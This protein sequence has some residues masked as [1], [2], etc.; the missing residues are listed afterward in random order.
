VSLRKRPLEEEFLPY[1]KTLSL[2]ALFDGE[3]NIDWLQ[4]LTGGKASLIFAALE[5]GV[6]NGWLSSQDSVN[7][8]FIES[9]EQQKLQDSLS[10]D[11]KETMHRSIA[12]L[13]LQNVPDGVDTKKRVAHHFLYL[14]NDLDGCRLLIERGD[15]HRRNFRDD[16]ARLYY[17]K[18]INDLRCHKG[19]QG[20]RLF[21]EAALQYAKVS[22]DNTDPTRVI[23]IVK[24][25]IRRAKSCG[26]EDS[27]GFLEMHLGKSEWLRSRYRPALRHFK[28]GWAL[29]R[30][31][32]DPITQRSATIFGIFFHYWSGNYREA[33]QSYE[34]FVPDVEDTFPKGSL[35]LLAA[36]TAG[37]CLGHTGLYSQALGML[38]AIREHSQ[39]IGNLSIAGLAGTTIGHLL[40]ELNRPEDSIQ[41]IEASLD[42]TIK[43]R[44]I[45]SHLGGLGLLCYAFHLVGDNTRA[46]SILREYLDLSSQA[47]M[48][49]KFSAVWMWICWAMEEGSFPRV[50]GL[51]LEEEIDYSIRSGNLLMKGVAYRYKALLQRKKDQPSDDIIRV[52]KRSVTH[53]RVCGHQ[54]ELAKSEVELAREYLRLGNEKKAMEWAEPAVKTLYSLND[55][56]VPDDIRPLVKDLRS[57]NLLEEILRLSQE[58]T[59]IRDHKDLSRRIISTINRITG[60]ERGAIF[61]LEDQTPGKI[62]LRAAKNLTSEDITMPDFQTP[63]RLIEETAKTG[64]GRI[65]ELDIREQ[66]TSAG[67]NAIRSCICVPMTIRN[68]AMGVLYHD[69]RLFRS[70]FKESDLKILDYFA[71]QA[72]IAIDNAQAWKT[73]NELY[74]KQ[75]LEKQYYEKEYLETIH[76][77]DFV[78]QSPAVKKVF[79]QVEQVAETDATVLILG[80]TGV[81]KEL[82]A[83]S[84]H[85]NSPRSKKP[86]IRVQCSAL[87]E[88]LISSELFGHERGAFTGATAQHIGRFELAN[89]GTIF[90]DEIGDISMDVQVRLLRVLQSREFERVGGHETLRSDFRLLAA[91]NR[92]LQ[93][94]VRTGH[95]RQDLYYR[96]NVFPIDVPRLRDREGDIQL[97]AYYFLKLYAS[98]FNKPLESIPKEEMGKLLA[99]DWP[100]NVREL[101]NV[102]ERGVILSNGPYYNVPELEGTHSAVSSEPTPI[103]LRDNERDHIIRVLKKTGGKV[104]G[105]GGA[106]DLL[107]IHPNTLFSRMK[108]LGIQRQAH[109]ASKPDLNLQSP[110]ECNTI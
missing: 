25:A 7:F 5:F 6:T 62:V 54:V 53:L 50:E 73:L 93:R 12:D 18:A 36:L 90:L 108:K 37:A 76:F 26:N 71:A 41:C 103:R 79:S 58:L 80:E 35:P 72:A 88:T 86:F 101:E 14:S 51:S 30:E 31:I 94:E 48:T 106:A 44:S 63:M 102:I 52:L 2:A 104:T 22:A 98:K 43:S 32:D 23:S 82:V 60:A 45:Y 100:G 84:I 89:G 10:P 28:K 70:A 4:E 65:L 49:V 56:L 20:D 27:V 38:H 74:E 13:L 109:Y 19:D 78:G 9:L 97:L 66:S 67:T 75:Q 87:P 16:E 110:S 61:L 3:F 8:S 91:T 57:G 17:D 99:Y 85:R 68:K 24:E 59:T 55:A 46:V 34:A 83:R 47:R 92:D 15:I 33:V 107:D 40:L 29:T 64:E 96:L 81:G 69:N 1:R 39:N 42:E 21:I 95:F 11:E 77:E 105:T